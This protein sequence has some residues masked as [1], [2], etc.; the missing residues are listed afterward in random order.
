MGL[1][2][3]GMFELFIFWSIFDEFVYPGGN[4]INILHAIFLPIFWR[5]KIEKPN[6]IREKLLNSL[7]YEK[8]SHKI[9]MKLTPFSALNFY[10]CVILAG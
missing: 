9:L 1:T 3:Y 7:S 10:L 8:R 6:V 5:Q 2:Y 4:F